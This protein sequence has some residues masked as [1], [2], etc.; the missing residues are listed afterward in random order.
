MTGLDLSLLMDARVDE[1]YS[2]FSADG[3]KQLLINDAFIRI[4]E[5]KY[6]GI[7]SSQK[8]LDEVSDFIA[9]GI[10]APVRLNRF[11]V[12][13]FSI[14]S[15]VFNGTIITFGISAPFNDIQVGDSFTVSDVAGVTG[16]N[17]TFV[18]SAISLNSITATDPGAAGVY[19]AGSGKL[20]FECMYPD[21]LH[22]LSIKCRMSPKRDGLNVYKMEAGAAGILSF[23]RPTYLRSEDM[24][25][26]SNPVGMI[27]VPASGAVYLKKLNRFNYAMY[28]DQ[29]LTTPISITGTYVGGASVKP[30]SY[31]SARYFAPDSD[32]SQLSAPTPEIPGV[33]LADSYINVYPESYDCDMVKMDY[34]KVPEVR[35]D[36][37]DANTNL[38]NF[39]TERF[40]NRI[41]DES[42]K[43]YYER[44]RDPNQFSV[45]QQS[46]QPNT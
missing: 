17:T 22:M 13:P 23:Y 5:D 18:V 30:V 39:Y 1:A 44:V 3:Q 15:I 7:G 43:L 46:S 33:R 4:I 2:D 25:V 35:I 16:V 9:S 42:L 31:R 32:I 14:S 21:Y 20:V 10:E 26:I 6:K 27:G 19:L 38:L 40:L 12:R 41:I 8:E 37:T 29:Y 45:S 36:V 11:R 28:S 34:V 24:A